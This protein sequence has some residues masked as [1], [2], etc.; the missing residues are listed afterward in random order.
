MKI[1]FFLL[2]SLPLLA[3]NGSYSIDLNKGQTLFTKKAGTEIRL[4]RN[5]PSKHTHSIKTDT[6]TVYNYP[7]ATGNFWEYISIDTI[8]IFNPLHNFRSSVTR[9]VLGDTFPGNGSTYKII[10][11]KY[12]ANT[13]HTPLRFE[14]QRV[15]SAGNVHLYYNSS[16]YIM[17]DFTK[18]KGAT[19][20]SHIPG[21][22][23]LVYDKWGNSTDTIPGVSFLLWNDTIS[24]GSY[25][26]LMDK[27]IVQYS[28][29]S[30]F[31]EN[32]ATLFGTVI[33]GVPDQELIIGNNKVDW[34]DYFPLHI[35]DYWVYH[36]LQ[37]YALWFVTMRILSDT[38]MDDGYKY[39]LHKE[40]GTVID[41]PPYS[42]YTYY[43]YLRLDSNG[44]VYEYN[45]F[46]HKGLV[47]NKFNIV[48]GDSTTVNFSE[49]KY[50]YF[51]TGK[52]MLN[53]N[54]PSLEITSTDYSLHFGL[55]KTFAKG[56]GNV[57]EGADLYSSILQGACINGVLYGDTTTTAI[58][59]EPP[60]PVSSVLYQNYPNPFNS[61]T[62]IPYMVKERGH[63][64]LCIYNIM[65]EVV[66]VLVK[67][68]QEAGYYEE[69][70][71]ATGLSSGMYL[72]HLE[73][74]GNSNTPVFTAIKKT[75]YLK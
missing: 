63:V 31:M 29:Y 68:E 56:V 48:V 22:H 16:D 30:N 73:V 20:P 61:S 4:L 71:D 66:K 36:T 43:K 67:K 17:F 38:V 9:E 14:L 10:K 65:G 40:F 59:D 39:Y 74:L 62:V 37:G 47:K 1:L 7:L 70:F 21:Y 8:T 53:D 50:Y 2:L 42:P 19:Y 26:I 55:R 24:I 46:Y 25:I 27:G 12:E 13:M 58:N 75:I 41:G 23:W 34:N 54:I 45:S 52:M 49:H 57:G 32:N 3:Q 5:F 18:P 64:K 35:G 15:D 72:I 33:N 69:K 6:S 28:L 51:V 44:S 60:V 11:W